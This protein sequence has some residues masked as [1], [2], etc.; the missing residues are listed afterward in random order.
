MPQR[1]LGVR[2]RHTRT[3]PAV[4]AGLPVASAGGCRLCVQVLAATS[5]CALLA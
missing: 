5:S 4:H 2:Q 3:K 1:L